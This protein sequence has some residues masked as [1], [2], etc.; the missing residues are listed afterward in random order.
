MRLFRVIV[1]YDLVRSAEA[2]GKPFVSREQNP[3]IVSGRHG[4]S[5]DPNLDLL[6]SVAVV[7]V[8]VDHTM[9]TS[10]LYKL[11]RPQ[12]QVA[13]PDWRLDAQKKRIGGAG[14]DR[15]GA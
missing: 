2:L 1:F 8:I 3:A 4:L 10:N 9:L 6:R 7:L 5:T 11:P 13:W 12:G 15:T 14:R